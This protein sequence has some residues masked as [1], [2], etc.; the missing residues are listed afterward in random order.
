MITNF[1]GLFK[2][3]Q[4]KNVKIIIASRNTLYFVLNIHINF[5]CKLLHK[6]LVIF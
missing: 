2:L 1:L 4:G 3:I 6:I 5:T